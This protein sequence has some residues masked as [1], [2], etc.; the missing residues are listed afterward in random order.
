MIGIIMIWLDMRGMVIETY[1]SRYSDKNKYSYYGSRNNRG[2]RQ[3]RILYVEKRR[4]CKRMRIHWE[5]ERGV[6]G[7]AFEWGSCIQNCK[8]GILVH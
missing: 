8:W 1:N 6:N 4:E 2:E 3:G 5:I 7:S